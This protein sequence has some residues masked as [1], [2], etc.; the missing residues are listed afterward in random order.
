MN[1]LR[2]GLLTLGQSPREDIMTEITPLFLPHIEIVERGLLDSLSP[3]EI[4]NLKPEI[5]ETPLVTRLKDGSQVHLS[6]KKITELLPKTIDLMKTNA[7]VKAVGIL[8]THDFPK[9]KFTCPVLFPFDYL[10]FLIN[11]VLEV[12]NLGVVV[13]LKNQIEMT[14]IKWE[15]KRTVVEAKSPYIKR[16][17]WEEII[18]RFV[19]EKVEALI[20]DCIG[21]KI[22]DAQEIQ[23]LLPVPILLPRTILTYAINQLFF[24]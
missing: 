10:R 24:S 7:N 15:K 9:T 5:K 4:V 6:E 16:K 20:L 12:R 2:I 1:K 3:E 17:S 23:R 8:C 14:K 18:Q 21:Y 11:C 13:P 19:Q 22:M